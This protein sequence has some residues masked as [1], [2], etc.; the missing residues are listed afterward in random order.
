MVVYMSP[1]FTPVLFSG[2]ITIC[3]SLLFS[4]TS[5]AEQKPHA[6][7]SIQGVTIVSAEQ[8]I[9]MIIN[10]PELVVIDSRKKTEYLKAKIKK[11]LFYPAAVMIMAFVVTCVLMIFVIPQFQEM[12]SNFGADL[13]ALTSIVIEMSK[14]FQEFWWLLFGGTQR[15][16]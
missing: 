5:Y 14:W 6:P 12:F 4:S 1:L 3:I 9:E 2:T 10:N 13:P 15:T 16:V 11:A 7:E 8:A